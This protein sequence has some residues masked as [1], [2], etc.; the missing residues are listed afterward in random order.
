MASSDTSCPLLAIRDAQRVPKSSDVVASRAGQLVRGC[1]LS[2]HL[3]ER[4]PKGGS[5]SLQFYDAHGD[6]VH[7]VFSRAGTD[8]AA[9]DR[10]VAEFAAADQ[11][12]GEKVAPRS[13]PAGDETPLDAIDAVAFRRDW[14]G[15]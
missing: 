3:G 4:G 5:R 10:L 12:A 14:L 15:M 9:W 8:L 11:S 1:E 6:A 7:K 2:E 13:A